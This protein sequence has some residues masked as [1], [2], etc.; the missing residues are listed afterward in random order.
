MRKRQGRLFRK[1]ALV[2][3]ALVGGTVVASSLL[4][5]YFSYQESRDALLRIER[6]EA[7]RAA[8]RISQFVDGVRI[9]LQAVAPPPGLKDVSLDQRRADFLA[10][11]R[12]APEIEETI[13]LDNDGKEQLRVSRLSLNVQGQAFDRSSDPEFARTRSGATYYGPVDFRAGSEPHFRVA[14]PE[15]KDAAV[16][17]ADVNLRFVLEPVSSIKVGEAGYAFV[18]DSAGRL[19]AH[20]DISA[21]LRLTDLS[22]LPQVQAALGEATTTGSAMTARSA[23]GSAVLTAF[24]KIPSTGW[25]VFVEQPLDEAF[26]PVNASIARTAW[27]LALALVASIAASLVLARRM[28][29]P[30]A[31][32]RLQAASIGAGAF[33]QRI[34]IRTGDELEGLADEFNRM[35]AQIQESY[36]HLEEKVAD[37]TQELATATKQLEL[38]S[39]NKSEFLANMSY[40][41]RTP[42]NAIIGFSE[43]LLERMFG[44]LNEKQEDYVRDILSSGKHQ[45]SLIN[46]ILD[47][48][49]VEAGRLE[50]ERSPFALNETVA[51]AVGLVR[52]RAAKHGIALRAELRPGLELIDGDERK[53]KQVLVNLLSNAVKFTPDGG[54]ID[55]EETW[56]DGMVTIAVRDTGPGIAPEDLD[57]IFREFEQ[58]AAARGQ[59]G[60]GLGLALAKRFVELHGGRIWVES[61][62]GRG[63]TFRFSL[64]VGRSGAITA[65]ATT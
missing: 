26:A 28:T 31:A 43:V 41:L 56:A 49:K 48:S 30:I 39:R 64:P 37:R 6:A 4:Q 23:S 12:R 7:S 11:Q 13:F 10:L 47:L 63:S 24:E 35:S 33:D 42:L 45:L 51:I 25:A 14:L 36:A 50:L 15:G 57:R 62:V 32:L 27:L 55:V 19:I 2:L 44:G 9:Q 18:V 17:I 53:V 38:A 20:P 46:D 22:S 65:S 52:E 16:T 59:E 1:Y 8:L 29:V 61:E 34:N 58:T 40:E 5:L 3:V 54:R 60:T 21:V